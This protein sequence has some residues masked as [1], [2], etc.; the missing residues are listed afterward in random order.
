MSVFVIRHAP[1][2]CPPAKLAPADAMRAAAVGASSFLIIR[3]P[4]SQDRLSSY[5][6]LRRK[7]NRDS[8]LGSIINK[9]I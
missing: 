2:A 4:F 6:T 1:T 5:P 7:F 9:S 3:S 8:P